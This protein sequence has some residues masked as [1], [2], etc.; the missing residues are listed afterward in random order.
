M[1]A[2]ALY[3]DLAKPTAIS[4]LDKLSAALPRKNNSDLRPWLEQKEAYTK[5]RPVRK[6]F[7]S[8]PYTVS[9]LLD[10]WKCDLLDLQSLANYNDMHRYILS[11]WMFSRNLYI[12]AP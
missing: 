11:V 2:R 7:L 9:N 5:H 10:A 3:Y 6:Q 12:W 4:T 1:S 8:N